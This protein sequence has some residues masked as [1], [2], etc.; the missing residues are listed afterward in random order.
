LLRLLERQGIAIA[1]ETVVP[2]NP[3]DKINTARLGQ[4]SDGRSGIVVL[5]LTNPQS[6]IH[7]LVKLGHFSLAITSLGILLADQD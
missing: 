1:S 3:A 7:A 5:G 6:T 2:G 4:I